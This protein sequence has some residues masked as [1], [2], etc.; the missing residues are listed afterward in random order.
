MKTC[1][2]FR[3]LLKEDYEEIIVDFKG[4]R[5]TIFQFKISIFCIMKKLVLKK[6]FGFTLFGGRRFYEYLLYEKIIGI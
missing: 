6:N 3:V 1:L 5:D 2:R 4:E